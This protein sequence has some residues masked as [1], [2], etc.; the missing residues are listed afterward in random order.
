MKRLLALIFAIICYSTNIAL[1]QSIDNIE[2][3]Q[4]EIH[5]GKVM[6]TATAKNQHAIHHFQLG[7]EFLHAFMYQLAIEQFR[8]AQKLDPGFM[9]AYWGEAMAYKHPIW[10]VENQ[11]ASRDAL[12]RYQTNKDGRKIS[13]KEAFYLQAATRYFAQTPRKQRDNDYVNTMRDFYEAYPNDPNVGAFYALSL[14]GRASDFANTSQSK[15]DIESGR[16]VITQLY[17]QFPQHPGVVHYFIHYHDVVDKSI[18]SRALPAAK[19][20]LTIMRSS[21]HVTHMAAHIFRRTESW[22]D[23]IAANKQSVEAANKVCKLINGKLNY[24]CNADNKYHS[25]EWLQYGY[26]KRHQY[27]NANDQYQVIAAVYRKDQSLPYKQWYYRMWARHV[28]GNHLWKEAPIKVDAITKD[29]GQLFWNGYTECTA[30]LAIGLQKAH[31]MQP[32]E[33]T[34]NRLNEVIALTAKL[35]GPYVTQTCQ[36]AKLEVQRAYAKLT[37]HSTQ[38]YTYAEKEAKI[39]KQRV[40]TQ[41]TPSLPIMPNT[42]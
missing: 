20:A 34:L 22:D 10:N 28:I 13:N 41:L 18:A 6:F 32:I 15:K 33:S 31:Q 25:L 42:L 3:L 26:L 19:T 4:S 27:K 11:Q 5:L 17:R 16:V 40:S 36:M 14:L 23:F 1:A 30:L 24:S 39:A 38:A 2:K 29:D 21:S 37:K 12:S 35:S 8:A 9:L 7:V